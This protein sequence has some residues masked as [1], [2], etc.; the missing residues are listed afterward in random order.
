MITRVENK[1]QEQGGTRKNWGE[2]FDS[3]RGTIQRRVDAIMSER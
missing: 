1:V 2:L 3:Q